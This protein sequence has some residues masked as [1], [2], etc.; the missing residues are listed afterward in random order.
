M[1]VTWATRLC[2]VLAA[3]PHGPEHGTYP[4]VTQD[5]ARSS[6]CPPYWPPE[7]SRIVQVDR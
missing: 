4:V 5:D 7:F 1:L 6:R 2:W 3:G